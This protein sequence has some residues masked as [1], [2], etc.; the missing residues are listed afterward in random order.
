[1]PSAGQEGYSP[2]K[3]LRRAQREKEKAKKPRGTRGS[4]NA[5]GSVCG[6]KKKGGGKCTLAS[7][8][9]TNH[10]GSGACKLHGGSTPN[11]IR[12]YIQGEAVLMGAPKEINPLDALLWCIKITAGEVD[13]LGL[14]IS[15][16]DEKDWLEDS[17][18]GKQLHLFA[19]ER[20]ARLQDLAKFSQMAVSLG[21]AE[22][23]V[24]LAEQYGEM[25]ARLLRGIEGGMKEKLRLSPEQVVIWEREWPLTLRQQLIVIEGGA[26]D[27]ADGRKAL[28]A[29]KEEAA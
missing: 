7:G 18:V 17:I 6:A 23:A 4:R 19:R 28:P 22:R 1:M 15:E 12:S 20:R 16:I 29:G 14:K 5:V 13:W 26:S 3:S 24:H 27:L 11:A 25:L 2:A 9:G 8:W 21:I 10:P